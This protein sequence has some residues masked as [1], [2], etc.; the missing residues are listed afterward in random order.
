MEE[1]LDVFRQEG[2]SEEEI[3][4]IT[5]MIEE[6]REDSHAEFEATTLDDVEEIYER[7]CSICGNGFKTTA[8]MQALLPP[9]SPFNI[10]RGC[11][12]RLCVIDEDQAIDELQW[13][14]RKFFAE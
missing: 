6:S 7:Q 5:Q 13:A 3:V 10:C 11:E 8:A 4:E 1:L 2:M 12:N 14:F 9:E